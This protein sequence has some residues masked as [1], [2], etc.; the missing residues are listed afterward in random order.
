MSL[1]EHQKVAVQRAKPLD[2]FGLFM[3]QGTGKSYTL[4]SIV[5][6]KFKAEG[7]QLR[8][9][10]L[11]PGIVIDNW[12]QEFKRIP[13]IDQNTIIP[14]VNRGEDRLHTF[15]NAPKDSIFVTNYQ[16]LLMPKLFEKMLKDPFEIII[17][18][19]SQRIKTYNSKTTKALLKLSQRAKYRYALSGTPILNTVSDIFPQIQFLDNG[20]TF[21]TNFFK[22]RSEYFVDF[23]SNMPRHCYFPN[24]KMKPET[25][26][27]IQKA[28]EPI[29][30]RVLKKD[31]L[32]LPPLV[33]QVVHCE[34]NPEQERIYKELEKDFVSSIEGTQIIT[35]MEL[36]KI[37]RLQQIVTG[38]IPD[39]N[40]KIRV[41]KEN[42]R[43]SALRELFES[44]GPDHKIIV[45]AC[46]KQNFRD[47]ELICNDA[48]LPYVEVHGGISP[49]NQRKNCEI[50]STDGGCRV[51]IGHPRSAGV[52]INLTAA[53]YAIFYSRSFSLEDDL[54]AE[55]RNYRGGS[56][57]HRSITRIDL[58]SP[59]TIDEVILEALAAKEQLGAAVLAHYKGQKHE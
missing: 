55:A 38:Y 3:E 53:S 47:I 34:M 49:P 17:C 12:K 9:L 44:I 59:N 27:R 43:N 16:A 24:W 46:F 10:I 33:K 15:L 1:W 20:E 5:Q 37:L 54:Q 30:M 21:G 36:T 52:G 42:S 39:A 25:P 58:L 40:D 23:N 8:T 32:D 26:D 7:R 56:E 6:D 50:F 35:D 4:C 18:D 45:W 19:E 11:C 13:E 2:Y 14:L 57:H 29:S 48:K 22:F 28:I 51:L 41:F 31:C